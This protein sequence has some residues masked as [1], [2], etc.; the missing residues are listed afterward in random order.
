MTFKKSVPQSRPLVHLPYRTRVKRYIMGLSLWSRI[1]IFLH[2][3]V[4][5]SK[6]SRNCRCIKL[7]FSKKATKI[8]RN[9]PLL[10]K[11]EKNLKGSLDSIPSPSP[12]VK[13]Q[14]MS[15]KV[16]LRCKGKTLLAFVNKLLNTKSLLASISNDLPYWLK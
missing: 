10:Y 7:R 16:C 1:D 11:V 9:S 8:W 6:T 14:I 12:S 2:F 15:R 4:S 3:W 13:I 5:M